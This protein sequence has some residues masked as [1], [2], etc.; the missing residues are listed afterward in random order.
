MTVSLSSVSAAT[1]RATGHVANANAAKHIEFNALRFGADGDPPPQEP[2]AAAELPK[3][4]YQ[5]KRLTIKIKDGDAEA[6]QLRWEQLFTL[7]RTIKGLFDVPSDAAKLADTEKPKATVLGL[8]LEIGGRDNFTAKELRENKLNGWI[9]GWIP[10][11]M[12]AGGVFFYKA[13]HAIL[14]AGG[15]WSGISKVGEM[16]FGSP[17]EE[18]PAAATS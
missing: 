7:T 3:G 15:F 14:N 10:A 6:G 11:A 12:E 13:K 1:Y 9:S 16:L 2:T 17:K 8:D 5:T 18:K 4:T